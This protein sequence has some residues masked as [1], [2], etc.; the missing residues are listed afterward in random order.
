MFYITE[1]ILKSTQLLSRLLLYFAF[2]WLQG[3]FCWNWFFW[4]E[5]NCSFKPLIS[6]NRLHN[7][8]PI[9]VKSSRELCAN[10]FICLFALCW[11]SEF[12]TSKKCSCVRQI[13][14]NIKCFDFAT[15]MYNCFSAQQDNLLKM[16][17]NY[18]FQQA[19]F[20]E[21]IITN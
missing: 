10:R 20:V 2:T 15:S 7:A 19:N 21:L 5:E 9:R 13:Y 11:N 8:D 3:L 18:D 14:T 6:K 4:L 1:Y 17:V 16:Y 12:T